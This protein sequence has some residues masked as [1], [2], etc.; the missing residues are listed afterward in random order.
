MIAARKSHCDGKSAW[1]ATRIETNASP[2]AIVT[3]SSGITEDFLAFFIDCSSDLAE[4]GKKGVDYS[5]LTIPTKEPVRLFIELVRS[6]TQIVE[7]GQRELPV[8]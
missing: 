4:S 2:C 6:E 5:K 7:F 3:F 1:L 8:R